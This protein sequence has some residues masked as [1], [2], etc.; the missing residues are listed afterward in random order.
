[1]RRRLIPSI[2]MLYN[3]KG[4][5]IQRTVTILIE[6]DADLLATLDAAQRVKQALSPI[7]FNGGKPLGP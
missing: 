1:M 4:M 3:A 6:T 5:E 2:I 7:A